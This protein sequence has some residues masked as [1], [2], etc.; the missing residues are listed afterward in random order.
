MKQHK[1][2]IYNTNGF[3]L[4][5]VIITIVKYLSKKYRGILCRSKKT[6]FQF[7]CICITHIVALLSPEVRVLD[8]I[9]IV[10]KVIYPKRQMTTLNTEKTEIGTHFN[11]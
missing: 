6:D 3:N 4:L 8:G 10:L 7:E 1:L 5:S 2:P 9:S 11:F